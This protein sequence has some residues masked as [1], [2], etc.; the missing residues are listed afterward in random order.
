MERRGFTLDG[1]VVAPDIGTA[2]AIYF[3]EKQGSAPFTHL[4]PA[5]PPN[6]GLCLPALV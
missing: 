3:A 5:L 4:R 6:M 1:V 2:E